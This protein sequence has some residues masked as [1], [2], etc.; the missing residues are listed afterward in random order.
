[1]AGD[2]LI[3]SAKEL[4]SWLAV[5]W[6]WYLPGAYSSLKPARWCA[7]GPAEAA[8]V[9][10]PIEAAT[11]PEFALS[12]GI[13]HVYISLENP[14]TAQPPSFILDALPEM[15]FDL[16][17]WLLSPLRNNRLLL[18]LFCPEGQ[19]RNFRILGSN[20][21]VCQADLSGQQQ[22]LGE[23]RLDFPLDRT[24]QGPRS[25]RGS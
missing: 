20:H 11:S 10:S 16:E 6:G 9:L 25:V 3:M 21:T 12:R 8:I 22:A 15:T 19:A 24:L 17:N 14:F 18:R 5:A 23:R 4:E 2:A 13:D 7:R 1:M